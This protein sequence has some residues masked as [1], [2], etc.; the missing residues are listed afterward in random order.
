MRSK[1]TMSLTSPALTEANKT[2]S[3]KVNINF[4]HLIWMSLTISADYMG[5]LEDWSHECTTGCDVN[6]LVTDL[7]PGS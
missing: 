5:G 4:F 2:V 6:F 1:N 7:V 3:P